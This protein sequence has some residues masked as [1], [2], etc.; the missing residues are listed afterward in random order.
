[1]N[2]LVPDNIEYI[3]ALTG[4]TGEFRPAQDNKEFYTLLKEK[5]IRDLD[6]MFEATDLRD[7]ANNLI[8]LYSDLDQFKA[9]LQTKIS[10]SWDDLVSSRTKY[11]G[12]YEKRFVL[13]GITTASLTKTSREEILKWGADNGYPAMVLCRDDNDTPYKKLG[14]GEQPWTNWVDAYERNAENMSEL[15]NAIRRKDIDGTA[16]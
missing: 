7:K 15:A 6:R 3:L 11:T 1:M 12:G 8:D 10:D 13:T 5:V 14:A 2:R 9:Q 16:K 4:Q